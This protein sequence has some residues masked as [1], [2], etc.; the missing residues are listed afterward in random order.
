MTLS[1][2]G[3][4]LCSKFHA[5]SNS[6]CPTIQEPD[7]FHMEH[8]G[9]MPKSLIIVIRPAS[10]QNTLKQRSPSTTIK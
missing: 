9:K 1:H 4:V 3:Y 5:L 2:L 8:V 6:V 10:N 7:P